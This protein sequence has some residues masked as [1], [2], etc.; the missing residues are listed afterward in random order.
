[1][2][3]SMRD[4]ARLAGVS[5]RTV[6]NVVNDYVHVKAETR[7]RVREAIAALNYRPNISA[8]NLRQGKTGV[9]SLAIP[10][11][12][13]PYFA[14]LA[15][16]VQRITEQRGQTLLINQ[17]GGTREREL[18][19]LEGY[20]NNLVDGLILSSLTITAEDLAHRGIDL[21]VVLLGES[22][23]HC[24]YLH[25]SIDNVEAATAATKHLADLGRRRIGAVGARLSVTASGPAMRRMQ[26][27]AE[28]LSAAGLPVLPDLTFAAADWTRPEGYTVAEQIVREGIKLDALFCFND[29]LALG[30][31][32]AFADLGVR[33]PDD[34]AV[35][36]WD[37]IEEAA[38]STPTL[39]S[40]AP[41]LNEIAQRAV[42]GLQAAIDRRPVDEDEITCRY[43]LKIRRSTA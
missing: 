41:D 30:A 35:F 23:D 36:G 4:V 27:Y 9:V 43:T 38:Y 39:S 1:M 6:S 32:K 24:G 20:N 7:E 2:A 18:L 12:A 10:Y 25:V 17:T 11:I 16:V 22:I 26:G 8:Q 3:T 34:I 5:Q 21:P 42:D 29:T 40:V 37:D 13:A 15:D 33:V 14:A 28:A 19:T 31:L